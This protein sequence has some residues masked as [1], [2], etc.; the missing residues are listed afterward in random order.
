MQPL[1]PKK[2]ILLAEDDEEDYLLTREAC[3]SFADSVDLRRVRNGEEL[4]DYLTKKS[5]PHLI[6]L[7]LNMPRKDGR[8]ALREVKANPSLRAIPVVVLTTSKSK[9]D[10]LQTYLLGGNSFIHKPDSFDQLVETMTLL[11]RYW[12]EIVEVS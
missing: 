1:E 7:D 3:E 4:L 6:L 2:I 10:I 11:K 5:R 8:E 12:L 9:E